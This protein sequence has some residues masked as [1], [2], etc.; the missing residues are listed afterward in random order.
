MKL[1]EQN[2][3]DAEYAQQLI[4]DALSKKEADEL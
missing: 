2:K 4:E 1:I 3:K